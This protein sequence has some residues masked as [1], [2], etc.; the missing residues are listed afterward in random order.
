MSSDYGHIVMDQLP[1]WFSSGTKIT[2]L[3]TL[4]LVTKITDVV[5]VL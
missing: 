4:L 2:P 3:N 1:L 5:T